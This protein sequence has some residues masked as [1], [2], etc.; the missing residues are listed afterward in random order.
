MGKTRDLFRK[1][2]SIKG[3]F[4]A[5]M[6]MKKDRNCKELTEAEEIK[7]RWQ[8]YTGKLYRKGLNDPDNHEG[9][10]THLELDVLKCEAKWA[11]GSII[12]NKANGGDRNP[13]E[14]FQILKDDVV[15]VLHS[16]CQY[17]SKFGKLSRGHR[18]GTGQFSFQSQ[19]RAM[20]NNVQTIIQ[21][22]LFHMLA[23]LCSKSFKLGFNST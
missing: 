22:C 21:L 17:A 23:R 8:E 4:H 14:L 18:I 7:K 11:F 13:A 5:R 16:I 15:R 20:A 12:T 19:R 3:T 1:I 9:V 2:G 6:G 10:V